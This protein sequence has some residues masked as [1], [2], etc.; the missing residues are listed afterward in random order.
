[1]KVAVAIIKLLAFV[2]RDKHVSA[3]HC[4]LLI[5]LA[6]SVASIEFDLLISQNIFICNQVTWSNQL[7]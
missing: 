2:C 6:G 1:M 7:L 5:F 4:S 3:E